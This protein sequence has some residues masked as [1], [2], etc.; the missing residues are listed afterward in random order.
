MTRL[1]VT[2]STPSS[3]L[4]A[5]GATPLFAGATPGASAR[6]TNRYGARRDRSHGHNRAAP[7]L[8]GTCRHPSAADEAPP[9]YGRADD[10]RATTTPYRQA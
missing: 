6:L 9:E 8:E 7:L 2:R 1:A 10:H 5:N 3:T 4:T